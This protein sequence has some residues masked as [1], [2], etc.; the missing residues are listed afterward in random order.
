MTLMNVVWQVELIES[1]LGWGLRIDEVIEFETEAKAKAFVKKFNSRNNEPT[2]PDWY[3]Y[4]T[5]PHQVIQKLK[6]GK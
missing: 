1:E 4:A 2:V 5:E 3:M 6:K